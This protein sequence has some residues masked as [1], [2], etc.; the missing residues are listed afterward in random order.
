MLWSKC[1]GLVCILYERCYCFGSNIISVANSGCVRGQYHTNN[2]QTQSVEGIIWFNWF[3]QREYSQLHNAD[4][5]RWLYTHYIIWRFQ[6]TL[7]IHGRILWHIPITTYGFISNTG[8]CRRRYT[9][10]T[11]LCI[12]PRNT[13][14]IHGRVLWPKPVTTDDFISNTGHCRRRYT[15]F[16]QLCICPWNTLKIHGRVLWPKPVTTDDFII[17]TGHCRRL[18]TRF[19]QLCVTPQNAL[20]IHG[21]VLWHK[22]ITTD[23]FIFVSHYYW[24]AGRPK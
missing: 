1:L 18:Y 10:F 6:N 21:R 2:E 3:L 13:L 19:T 5:Y 8:H 7:R 24:G 4:E 15:R 20:K 23:G 14:K 17:N 11:Q 22:P 12:C 9:R 16:T